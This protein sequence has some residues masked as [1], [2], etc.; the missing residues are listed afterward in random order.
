[1]PEKN[2]DD[3]A[4]ELEKLVDAAREA[5]LSGDV[6]RM[7]AAHAAL[8]DFTSNSDDLIHGIIELDG[9][10]SQAMR[11]VTLARLDQ[12]LVQNLSARSADIARL[13]KTFSS[14]SAVNNSAAS[15]LRLERIQAV[16]EA[17]TS[18]VAEL[19]KLAE[20]VDTATADGKKLAGTLQDAIDAV[21]AVQKQIAR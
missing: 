9:V 15:A 19:R 12:S 11:D 21:V 13:V 4:A 20:I 1:M 3:Y 16:L 17:G 10:A 2:F 18:A 7:K 6:G 8:G 14:Q 5:I